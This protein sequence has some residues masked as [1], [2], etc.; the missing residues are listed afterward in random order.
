MLKKMKYARNILSIALCAMSVS[1]KKDNSNI[2]IVSLTLVHA[3]TNMENIAVSFSATPIPFYKSEL[4]ISY[5]SNYEYGLPPGENAI[6]I[7]SSS[8]TSKIAWNGV[9]NLQSGGIYSFYLAGQAGHIDTLFH[10]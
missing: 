7:L 3:T 6:S 2:G 4:L 5:S 10:Q 1:C 9:L 8:D